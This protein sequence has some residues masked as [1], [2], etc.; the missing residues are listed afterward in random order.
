[1]IIVIRIIFNIIEE[2]T[3]HFIKRVPQNSGKIIIF[4]YSLFRHN[5]CEYYVRNNLR[6]I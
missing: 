5:S 2:V 1:M 4:K 3:V 6:E